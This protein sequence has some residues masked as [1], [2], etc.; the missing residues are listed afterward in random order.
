MHVGKEGIGWTAVGLELGRGGSRGQTL[1]L[2]FTAAETKEEKVP[3]KEWFRRNFSFPL[4]YFLY[5]G[6]QLSLVPPYAELPLNCSIK[7]LWDM[8]SWNNSRFVE[9]DWC[10]GMRQVERP[11]CGY[12]GHRGHDG[13]HHPPPTSLSAAAF[14]FCRNASKIW[15]APERHCKL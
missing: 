14:L 12:L 4:K 13:G 7:N 10:R 2:T 3:R 6:N 15:L 8:F 9:I 5:T 1:E 11:L